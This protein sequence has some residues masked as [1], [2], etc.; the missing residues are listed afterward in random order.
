MNKNNSHAEEN[1]DNHNNDNDNIGWKAPVKHQLHLE[2]ALLSSLPEYRLIK[3]ENT[4][5]H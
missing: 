4:L 5:M 2:G 1:K 3:T